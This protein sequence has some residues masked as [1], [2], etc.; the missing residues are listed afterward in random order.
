MV[1]PNQYDVNQDGKK[2]EG[3]VEEKD[4]TVDVFVDGRKIFRADKLPG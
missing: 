3:D 2:K 4:P 1:R